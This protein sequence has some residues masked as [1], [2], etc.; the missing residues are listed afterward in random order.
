MDDLSRVKQELLELNSRVAVIDASVT[1]AHRSGDSDR[2]HQLMLMLEKAEG[3][4][5]GYI[6]ALDALGFNVRFDRGLVAVVPKL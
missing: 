5:S 1:L 4:L 6:Q 3:K 2:E